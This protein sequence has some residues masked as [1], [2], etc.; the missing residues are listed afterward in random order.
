MDVVASLLI[1]VKDSLF[2]REPSECDML[3][4]I[5]TV[6]SDYPISNRNYLA[7]EKASVAPI[8]TWV[9]PN[10]LTYLRLLIAF[11]LFIM[12]T[13]LSYPYVLL[14]TL[15]GGVS[16]YLDG[17]LARE[18]GKKTK[19]GTL[20]DPLADKLLVM[21]AGYILFVRGELGYAFVAAVLVCEIHVVLI[22]VFSFL[23]QWRL[24]GNYR[25]SLSAKERM[26]PLF[27]GRV[28][29]H[30]YIYS[31]LFILLGRMVHA[32]TIVE[33]GKSLLVAGVAA[34]LLSLLQYIVRWAKNP[35]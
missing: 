26:K 9:E 34:G 19:L 23:Y 28:K 7:F 29:V 17:A 14:L 1:S 13:Q 33:L 3:Q 8:P 12:S 25:S 6:P 4:P 31:L 27:L 11:A 35:Y 21:A 10:Y 16:D 18:R 32:V 20:L 5:D 30:L 24:N 2:G 15:V 22:P